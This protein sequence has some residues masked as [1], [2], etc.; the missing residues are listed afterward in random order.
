MSTHLN[1]FF[2]PFFSFLS[3]LPFRSLGMSGGSRETATRGRKWSSDLECN[4]LFLQLI[5]TAGW[6]KAALA[7][8]QEMAGSTPHHLH[9]LPTSFA[10][11]S[12]LGT[13]ACPQVSSAWRN[14]SEITERKVKG[15][16]RQITTV[17]N[18]L[19]LQ[20]WLLV[21]WTPDKRTLTNI[22]LQLWLLV[23][24]T[25]DKRTTTNILLLQLWLL[26]EW[27]P[28]KRTFTNILQLWL[29][30]EWTPDKMTTT[31]ILQLWLLVE[32]TPDKMTTTNI[33]Q[34][35]L[36]V[37]WNPDKMTTTNILLLQLWLLVEWNPDKRTTTNILLLQLWLLVEWTPDKMTTTNI[38]Q[39][40]LLVEWTPDKR[41]ITYTT[42]TALTSSRVD[43]W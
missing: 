3:S 29:L 36:L 32:W 9:N 2:C 31:N 22:L 26:V 17:T 15:C 25:P 5:R 30:V 33:L 34:L 6:W 38:L 27:T 35:W 4:V 19:Q 14:Q 20:L 21:E 37:E 13:S 24:W 12:L 39:L 23:E 43:P 16:D 1:I 11:S 41:T 8:V 10:A 40:R 28:D 7:L 42:T 18:I